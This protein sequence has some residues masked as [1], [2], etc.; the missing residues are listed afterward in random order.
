MAVDS[1]EKRVTVVDP[2]SGP[3]AE[4][5]ERAAGLHRHS[6][7][8]RWSDLPALAERSW[9]QPLA[10]AVGMFAVC[11]PAHALG[12]TGLVYYLVLG[13]LAL[14][15]VALPLGLLGLRHDRMVVEPE[16]ERPA[17]P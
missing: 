7:P 11:G 1:I 15:A 17:G 5:R 2:T 10:L 4:G 12:H 6:R 3:P 8:R 13:A 14:S 16:E 9:R